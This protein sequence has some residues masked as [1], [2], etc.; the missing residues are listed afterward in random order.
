MARLFLLTLLV[1]IALIQV[2]LTAPAGIKRILNKGPDGTL[3]LSQGGSVVIGHEKTDYGVWAIRPQTVGAL[4]YNPRTG[5]YLGVN[6]GGAVVASDKRQTWSLESAGDNFYK[7]KFPNDDLVLDV[8]RTS[9]QAV[10]RRSNGSAEQLW[11][12]VSSVDY[13]R[14]Y[15]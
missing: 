10:L 15:R 9:K 12:F 6:G 14:M 3:Q 13:S 11:R 2:A 1:L 5:E 4:L 7:I 8:D